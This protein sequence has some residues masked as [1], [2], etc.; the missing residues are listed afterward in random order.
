MLSTSFAPSSQ[1]IFRIV[2]VNIDNEGDFVNEDGLLSVAGAVTAAAHTTSFIRTNLG[3]I[4]TILSSMDKHGL[5]HIFYASWWV[6]QEGQHPTDYSEITFEDVENKKWMPLFEKEWSIN[7][8]KALGKITIWPVH[9]VAGTAGSEIVPIISQAI[10]QHSMLRGS[11]HIEIRKGQNLRTE[12]YGIFGAEVEDPNDPSTKLNVE[13]M[14]EISG[15]HRSYWLGQEAN[16]CVRRSLEQYI[17]WC[18]QFC[19]DAISRIRYVSDCISLLPLGTV[20]EADFTRSLNEMVKK[21][22]V[23]VSST[24]PIF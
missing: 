14:R 21:G 24:D 4:T 5:K 8:V 6:N 3:R 11:T 13:R 7:Y 23:I 17:T 22:L 1:D 2:L 19:P 9:C 16:H 20:Y 18:E 12:H 10:A 15:Y